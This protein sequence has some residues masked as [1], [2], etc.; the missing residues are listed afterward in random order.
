M[1]SNYIG[2]QNGEDAT[3]LPWYFHQRLLLVSLF[4]SSNFKKE[5]NEA[6]MYD[7]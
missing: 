3:N 2:L 4:E 1:N 5:V 6:C 7:I